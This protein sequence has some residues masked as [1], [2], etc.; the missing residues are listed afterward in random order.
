MFIMIN[1]KEKKILLKPE[2]LS[3]S[4]NKF[5]ILGVFNPGA[6]R[7]AN[8]DIV[9]YVR[10]WEKLIKTEDKNYFYAPRMAGR[11]TFKIVIDK[12]KKEIV[13]TKSD[14]DVV[15]KDG[16][17]RITFISYFKRVILDTSGFKIKSIDKKP[18]FYGLY[19]DGEFG[20]E[21]PR[22]TRVGKWYVMTYVSLSKEQN[23]S[24]S[25]AIS[26]DCKNWKRRGIIFGEQDKDVVIFPRKV[27]GKY[28]AFD[29]PESNFQFSLPHIWIAYSNNLES[30]GDL[31]PVGCVYKKGRTCPRNGAGPPPIKTDKGWLLIY[32]A[33]IEKE[34]N[35]KGVSEY[36]VGA[37]LFNLKNPEKIIATTGKPLL[38][39]S[40][41]EVLVFNTK[42][43]IFPTGAVLDKNKKDI[44][45]FS[46]E[47][48]KITTVNKVSLKDI[49]KELKRI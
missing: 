29:R 9:L 46:G 20:V 2:D 44:L 21:D 27:K 36:I 32:H 40:K 38:L 41:E 7:L 35:N 34:E 39:P 19:N 22:I 43:V 6:I 8:G 49:L 17:K 37:A 5:E 23:I 1:I 26:T 14:L 15:F 45:I 24:T 48:D 13:R 47:S 12:F 11:K 10:I 4:S 25:L 33:V 3:P 16:T 31:K 28:V 18:S 42:R 30:W